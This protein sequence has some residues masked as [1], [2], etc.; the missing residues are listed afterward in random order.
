MKKIYQKISSC[1]ISKDKN[2]ISVCNFGKIRLTGVFPKNDK[3]IIEKTPLEVVFSKKSKLLQLNHNYSFPKLFGMNYGYR[4]ALNQSMVY[5]LEK[6]YKKLN[7]KLKFKSSD[8]VLDIGSNDGTFLKF[9]PK[10][11]YKIGCDPTANKFKKY[12]DKSI[13]I[14]PKIFDKNSSKLI[15]GKFKLISSIAMFYDL[16]DPINFCKLIEK[17][18]EKNGIFHLEIAYLPFIQKTFSFDT[19]CQEHLTYFSLRSFE[20]LIKQTNL[21]ILDFEKNLINGGS[22]NF[23]LALK[24]SDQKVNYKKIQSLRQYEIKN[25]VNSLNYIKYFFK[26]VKTNIKK[27]NNNIK[28]LNGKV[29]GFGASTKGNV[30]LQLCNLNNQ[31]IISIYD[32]N[33][34]KFGSYTPGSKIK[35]VNEKNII[36]DQPKYLIFLIWHFK[37]TISEKLKKFKLKKTNYIWLF[38]KYKITKSKF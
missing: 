16:S 19:F 8:R 30:T 4:S 22:I 32:I 38:P 18:L 13:K 25:K 1:R 15:E 14:L 21:K 11:I 37:K 34:E 36:K 3:Q 33:K 9:F 10:K 17:K 35:I 6:K 20:Y 5:H 12:Y 31:N 24:E 2:L 28:S 29:Y 7:Q 23:N 27:I 26:L